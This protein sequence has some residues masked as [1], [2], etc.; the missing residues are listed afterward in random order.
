M[1]HDEIDRPLSNKIGLC[2]SELISE[3]AKF[4]G[5]TLVVVSGGYGGFVG[6]KF[7]G[8]IGLRLFANS[9][10]DFGPD[11]VPDHAETVNMRALLILGQ[12]EDR[13][14]A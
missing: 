13:S 1:M 7:A 5:S 11:E 3:L 8:P 6:V 2:V 10:P 12:T 4:D 9:D 14:T